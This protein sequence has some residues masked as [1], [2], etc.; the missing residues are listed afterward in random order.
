MSSACIA[1]RSVSLSAGS[2]ARSLGAV[3]GASC[4][5]PSRSWQVYVFV[6][7]SWSASSSKLRPDASLTARVRI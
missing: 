6:R 5:C 1:I 4:A 3:L 2:S 7:P